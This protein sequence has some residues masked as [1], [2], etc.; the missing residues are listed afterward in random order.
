MWIKSEYVILITTKLIHGNN[1][2][3]K[4]KNTLYKC[5]GKDDGVEK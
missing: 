3:E 4:V 2:D 1:Y 5:K